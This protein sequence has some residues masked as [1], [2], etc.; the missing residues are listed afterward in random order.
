MKKTLA[1]LLVASSLAV[2]A[3]AVA[4]V[5]LSVELRLDAG[6][7]TGDAADEVDAG[8]GFGVRASLD[9]APTFALYGGYS[10]FSF[11]YDDGPILGGSEVELEGFELGGRVGLGTG[12]GVANPYAMLG[13]LFHEDETG[14]EAGLGAD[15]AVSYNL[16]VTPEVR[17]R[18][19]GD[20]NYISLGLGARFRF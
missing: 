7:P 13:A 4:Q 15:Y 2:A 6:I 14:L 12:G 18:T 17:Y 1:L 11:D 16:S 19:I 3:P 5:P 9:L 10:Q 20:F 8:V